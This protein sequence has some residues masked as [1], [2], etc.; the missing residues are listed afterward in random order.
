MKALDP[1]TTSVEELCDW[2]ELR[3]LITLR[4]DC[5]KGDIQQYVKVDDYDIND[6]DD[7]GLKESERDERQA[8]EVIEH[9]RERQ[10]LLGTNYLF[11]VDDRGLT[12]KDLWTKRGEL[13]VQYEVYAYH[14]LLSTID[15]DYLTPTDRHHFET[16]CTALLAEHF[17]AKHFHFG[18]TKHNA[19]L[20]KIESRVNT[21]CTRTSIRWKK[22]DQI[23]PSYV[24]QNDV[25]VDI[26]LW[27]DQ[28]DKR[29]NTL[30]LIGQC[31]SGRNW[32]A[33][34]AS[35]ADSVLADLLQDAPSAP[36]TRVFCL[37]FVIPSWHWRRITVESRSI[38]YDR[39]RLVAAAQRARGRLAA[40][41]SSRWVRRAL[42]ALSASV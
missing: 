25:G 35:T 24:E 23:D 31:A 19:S 9:A 20:G 7:S 30:V 10:R 22:K 2:A 21:L 26:V 27:R 5:T 16:E 15:S 33:K 38:V 6:L 4:H 39:V 40:P 11:K 14:L 17:G 12:A 32:P 37:P 1:T 18:W 29:E 28:V 42:K 34:I 8:T 41:R 3:A 36:I 13:K